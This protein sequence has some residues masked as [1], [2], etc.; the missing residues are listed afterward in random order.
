MSQITM[1]S[2]LLQECASDA[3]LHAKSIHRL[4]RLFRAG[5]SPEACDIELLQDIEDGLA[6]TATQLETELGVAALL[7]RWER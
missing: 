5:E 6:V 3:R 7:D 4:V 2:E 1:S